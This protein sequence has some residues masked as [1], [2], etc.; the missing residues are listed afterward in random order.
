MID[1]VLAFFLICGV[2]FV[3]DID[4]FSRPYIYISAY[5]ILLLATTLLASEHPGLA[6]L[7]ATLFVLIH[8]CYQGRNFVVSE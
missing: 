4:L 1:T 5:V 6:F 2:V 3:E 8:A 7:S